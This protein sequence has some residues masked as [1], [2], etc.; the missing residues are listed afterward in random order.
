MC[1]EAGLVAR[2]WPRACAFPPGS[3]M[4]IVAPMARTVEAYRQQF[5]D[6][7]DAHLRVARC[8]HPRCPLQGAGPLTLHQVRDRAAWETSDRADRA[9]HRVPIARLKCAACGTTH[10]LLPD[11]LAPFAATWS[12]CTRAC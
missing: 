12:R 8:P 4:L 3:T 2:L 11:F 9:A 10:T 5:P 6:L 7:V 1:G